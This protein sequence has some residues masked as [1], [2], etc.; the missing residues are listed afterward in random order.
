MKPQAGFVALILCLLPGHAP[1]ALAENASPRFVIQGDTVLDTRTHLV[2][3]RCSVG[4]HWDGKGCTGEIRLVNW[5]EAQKLANGEWRLPTK[6]ELERLVDIERKR[7]R[8][9]PFIDISAFPGTDPDTF[10]Y[11]TSSKGMTFAYAVGFG[12]E[13]RGVGFNDGFGP[14][15]FFGAIRLVKGE[16][17]PERPWVE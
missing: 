12:E 4:Q 1:S 5:F 16:K 9:A 13:S 8:I 10:C 3:Q 7:K 17:P 14:R 6:S 2:W 11:W 15:F